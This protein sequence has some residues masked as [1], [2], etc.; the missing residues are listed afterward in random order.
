M[1]I[2]ADN[3]PK[4]YGAA[5][6]TLTA[7]YAGFVNGESPASLITQPTLSTTAKIN[8]NVGTYPI[9]V[10]GAT[11]ANYTITFVNGTLTVVPA[12]LTITADNKSKIYGKAVPSLTATYTGFVNGDTPAKLDTPVTLSTTGTSGS[13]VGTYPIT[14]SG[15]ADLNYSITFV[16]GT[17]TVTPAPL[18]ITAANK[19]RVYGAS[20]PALTATYSGFVN[21][22]TATNLD[23]PVTLSTSATAGSDVGTYPIVASGASG[24]NYTVTFVNGTLTITPAGLTIKAQSKSKVYGAALPAFTATY[25]GFVNGDT[26][27]SLTTPVTFTTTATAASGVGTYP[28]SP[29]GA[30]AANYTITFVNGTL[31]VAAAPL[32]ITADNKT[33]LYGDSVPTLTLTYAGF[34]LGESEAVLTTPASVTTTATASSGAGGYPITVS[35]ATAANYTIAF[36]NGTLTVAKAPLT[37]T[38]QDATKVYG[39]VNPTFTATYSG[40]VNGDTVASL[41][42]AA[43]VKTTATTGSP[44]GSYPITPS[45]AT[46]TNYTFNYVNGTLTVTPAAL[47]VTAQNK[48]KVYGAALPVFTATYTGFVNGDT[49]ASLTTPVTFTTTATAAS[50]VGT[51]P[52]SASGATAANYT[53]AFVNGTLTVTAAPLTITADNKSKLYGDPVP[54]LT[55]TYSGF[56]LGETE[57]VLATPASVATA[58]TASSSAGTYPITVSGATAANYTIAFV[59]GTLTVAKVPLT[60]TAQDATKVYGSVNPTFTATYSGFVNGDTVASLTKAATVKTTATTGSPVASYPITPSGATSTNYTFNYVNGTLTVTPAALTVTAQNKS[61]VYGAAL[62]VFTATYTGFVNGDTAASLTTPVTFTTTA[63]AA[64]GVGTYP[65]SASGA[66]AANYTIAFVNGTLSVTPAALTITAANKTKVYGASLPAFTA[67]YTGFVNGDT[68]ASLTTPVTFTTTATAASGVG[69]Y[70]I[71]PS[72]ATS[73]NYTVS[74]VN[75]TLTVTKAPLTI[76]ADNKTK[77]QGTPNPPLTATYTGLV[78]GDTPASLDTPVTLTTTATTRSPV[79]TYVIKASGAKASNYTITF[80]NGTLTVVA[81]NLRQ[82][83]PLQVGGGSG[84]ILG[85][86]FQNGRPQLLWDKGI[87]Q[88]A[89]HLT[90]PWND[91]TDAVSPYTMETTRGMMFY[92][93][94]VSPGSAAPLD[95][96]IR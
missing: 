45:G 96:G 64:S 15:A 92:R 21:G 22:D 14:A 30:T 91:V 58:A 31:T 1:T 90:G 60:V 74:F 67:T 25:T 88:R 79:G 28:I 35:G 87:L 62:P 37:V 32:T 72:G 93:I 2:S 85:L 11:A 51:Y 59:N 86:Q 13:D 55:L 53:I 78:N 65:I 41:T 56:V 20:L 9:T 33:K 50:G 44:V 57:A 47:T 61:K 70:P 5:L 40:F 24:H 19:T 94:R 81:A 18:T 54:T 38:A 49:A 36:V 8:S 63:T 52:I 27:A 80:V 95:G 12:P 29:S 83:A 75:G 16:P 6:P 69:S 68:A 76:T 84:V 77:I 7:S 39:S 89:N 46:S 82:G 42:K 26:A 10:S 43:T 17:L 4:V 34:V 66:T 3:V 71:S 23:T 48:S 73:P